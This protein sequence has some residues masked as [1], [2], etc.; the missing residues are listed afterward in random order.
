MY[1]VSL[2][3]LLRIN[4]ITIIY[5]NS[6]FIRFAF[7]HTTIYEFIQKLLK[8]ILLENW[9]G[10][11]VLTTCNSGK[12]RK[13]IELGRVVAQP[14]PSFNEL[15]IRM[16]LVPPNSRRQVNISWCSTFN[17]DRGNKYFFTQKE[18]V[19]NC[20]CDLVIWVDPPDWRIQWTTLTDT[21]SH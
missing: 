1:Y 4:F 12:P 20:L 17:N 10:H 9:L 2:R 16:V 19:V 11:I 13:N 14:L 15:W 5:K 18:F 6:Y 7:V 8:I 21:S 3:E